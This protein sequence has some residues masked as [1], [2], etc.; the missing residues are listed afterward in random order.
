MAQ[1]LKAAAQNNYDYVGKAAC[2]VKDAAR[3]Y[4]SAALD[5]AV[6]SDDRQAG[7][8]ILD[9]ER[10]VSAQSNQI[11][12]MARNALDNQNIPDTQQRLHQV[13][14]TWIIDN[15]SVLEKNM[16]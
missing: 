7:D 14:V 8:L 3:V 13:R 12:Q 15:L 16:V 11:L 4:T 1:L 5:V 10:E 9:S 6:N 2:D